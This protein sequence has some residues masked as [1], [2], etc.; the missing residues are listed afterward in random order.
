L[1]DEL[2]LAL[3]VSYSGHLVA[4]DGAETL[5]RALN[6]IEGVQD[7]RLKRIDTRPD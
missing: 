2:H 3:D 6:R 7:V 5:V 1:I 4:E